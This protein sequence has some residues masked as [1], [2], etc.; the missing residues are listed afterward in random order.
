MDLS[1]TTKL[2]VLKKNYLLQKCHPN[3]R[4]KLFEIKLLS[5]IFIY[6]KIQ[7]SFKIAS[8]IFSMSSFPT[9]QYI[10]IFIFIEYAF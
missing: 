5:F 4:W 2:K 10:Y 7:G 3:L 9:E 1:M 8:N 6:F